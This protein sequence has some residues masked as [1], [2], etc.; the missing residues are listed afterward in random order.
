[1]LLGLVNIRG[2]IRLCVSL[3]I[4]WVWN[5]AMTAAGRRTTKNPRCLVVIAGD[6]DHWVLLV[7]EL[8]GIQRFISVP[9]GRRR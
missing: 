8:H 9:Y 7:D 6:S 1:M 4:S 2:Q 3:R 5:Q